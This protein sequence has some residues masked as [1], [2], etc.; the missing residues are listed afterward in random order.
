MRWQDP[1]PDVADA[2]RRAEAL[3]E[4]RALY[5]VWT[6]KRIGHAFDVDHCLPWSAWRCGDLWNLL[7]AHPGTNRNSKGDKLPSAEALTACADR[8]QTWWDAA[9][10]TDDG[11]RR[12]L[13]LE[14]SAS[15]PAIDTATPDLQ[16]VFD[17]LKARRAAL[18]AQHQLAEWAP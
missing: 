15:L 9:Y 13:E 18:M 10:R 12:R 11:M 1:D 4:G 8:I 3:K 16:T 7:P 5:C 17:G 14:A 6:G 2:R